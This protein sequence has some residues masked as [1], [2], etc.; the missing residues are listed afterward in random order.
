ML[1][2]SAACELCGDEEGWFPGLN[3]LYKITDDL[4]SIKTEIEDYLCSKTDNLFNLEN[5]IMLFDLTNFYFEGRKARRE[6]AVFG[7]SKE[8]R[9]DCKL[10]VLALCINKE[11]FIRYSDILEG[12]MSDA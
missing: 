5:R 12:N 1:N 9:N 4:F 11:G 2:N 7:R 6:K 10:L 3:A 8:K